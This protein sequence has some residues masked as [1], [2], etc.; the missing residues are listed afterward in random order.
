MRERVLRLPGVLQA[1]SNR[2][3]PEQAAEGPGRG[4]AR[5]QVSQMYHL[6]WWNISEEIFNCLESRGINL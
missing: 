5:K 3:R 4:S 6:G 2:F 1:K